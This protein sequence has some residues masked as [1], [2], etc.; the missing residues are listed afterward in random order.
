MLRE[1]FGLQVNAGNRLTSDHVERFN[2]ES[3][4][5]ACSQCG[6]AN[7]TIEKRVTEIDEDECEK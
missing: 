3:T 1:K 7:T 4:D 5:N 6:D 2:K